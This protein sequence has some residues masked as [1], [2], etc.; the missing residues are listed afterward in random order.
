[1]FEAVGDAMRAIPGPTEAWADIVGHLAWPVTLIFLVIRFRKALQQGVEKIAK[2]LETDDVQAY[3]LS[4][5]RP[6]SVVPLVPG[7][8]ESVDQ[9]DAAVIE[10]LFELIDDERNYD[11]LTAWVAQAF[12]NQVDVDAFLTD[13]AYV[14]ERREA[15]SVLTR[16]EVADG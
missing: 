13:E 14:R 15:L 10:I 3:G 12:T 1:M 9:S 16:R 8:P 6:A 4:L 11:R 2:R 7:E 5:K